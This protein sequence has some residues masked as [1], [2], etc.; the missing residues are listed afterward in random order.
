MLAY[1]RSIGA[2]CDDDSDA[3]EYGS[4]RGSVASASE[5]LARSADATVSSRAFSRQ[6]DRVQISPIP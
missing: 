1:L 4:S 3:I 5:P 6:S 2:C